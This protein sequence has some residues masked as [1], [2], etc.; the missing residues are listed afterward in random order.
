MA[1]YRQIYTQFW[2]DSFVIELTP[3]EKF[4]YLYIISNAKSTQ[5]GIYEISPKF[6]AI[7]MGYSKDYVEE[8]ICRFCDFGKILYCKDTKE[9]MV[10]NWIKY[11]SPNNINSIVGV[12]KELKRVKNKEFIKA[13]FEKCKDA[14]LDVKKIFEDFVVEEFI[15]NESILDSNLEDDRISRECCLEEVDKRNVNDNQANNNEV[16][17]M[18]P[19][20]KEINN[21]LGSPLQAPCKQVGSNRIRSKEEEVINNEKGLSNKE[22]AV[23]TK[24]AIIIDYKNNAAAASDGIK[25]IIKVFE[26][27]IHVITPFVYEKILGFSKKVSVEVIIM[28]IYEAV[29]YNARTMKY[30]T[31]IL[32]NWISNDIKIE[33]QVIAYQKQWANKKV[34]STGKEVKNG[35]FCDYDQRVYDFDLLEKRL[36]GQA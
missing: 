2:S 20:Y 4:F 15:E 31:K 14:Q 16:I 5:S 24:E 35:G 29:S 1:K 3:E 33:N 32:N 23:K 21:P 22:E 34:I 36:L 7:E 30:I 13:L 28:A 11:N 27:N 17:F 6:I 19:E 8:L 18:K 10:L 25:K 9:I 12:Q 26:E